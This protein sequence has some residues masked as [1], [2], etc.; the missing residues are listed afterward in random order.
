MATQSYLTVTGHFVAEDSNDVESVVLGL[1][2]SNDVH[3]AKDYA[4]KIKEEIVDKLKFDANGVTISGATTDNAATMI[5]VT[6]ELNIKHLPCYAHTIQLVISDILYPKKKKKKDDVESDSELEIV[7]DPD[8][9][10]YVCR[11]V[12]SLKEGG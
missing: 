7:A 5:A 3:S 9:Y 11:D 1:V 12:A 2:D 4:K 8:I 10:E 6:R